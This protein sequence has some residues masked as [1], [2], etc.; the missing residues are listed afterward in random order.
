MG[1][2]ADCGPKENHFFLAILV[3]NW[4]WDSLGLGMLLI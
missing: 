4:V 3:S 2:I 1:Y